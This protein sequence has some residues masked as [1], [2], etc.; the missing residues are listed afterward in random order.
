MRIPHYS[1]YF[2]VWAIRPN[3]LIAAVDQ[4]RAMDLE[5]HA[6]RYAPEKS[7]GDT[8]YSVDVNGVAT[9]DVRGELTKYGSSLSDAPAMS[10]IRKMMRAMRKDDEVKGAMFMVDSPGGTVYGL[11]DLATELES[12]SKVKPTLAFIQDVGASA[13]YY[14]AA[15]ANSVW[16][17][18][19]AVVGSIGT[20]A[21]VYDT[22][23]AAA[24]EGV[25]VHVLSTAPLKGAGVDGAPVTPVQLAEWQKEVDAFG[26]MFVNAVASGR[27]MTVDKARELATGEVWM[28]AKARDLGLVDKVGDEEDAYAALLAAMGKAGQKARATVQRGSRMNET[29]VAAE[30]EQPKA[31]TL[32]ELKATL[33]G[34][35]A[36]FLLACLDRNLTATEALREYNRK[37]IADRAAA[38]AAHK[39]ELDKARADKPAGGPGV[40]EAVREAAADELELRLTADFVGV[41]REIATE[42][43]L[44]IATVISQMAR[45]YPDAH[46]TWLDNQP[47]RK[48]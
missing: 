19:A 5:T 28:A 39:T 13:A 33:D 30:V 9:V 36:D 29:I 11:D 38:D 44:G 32:A 14:F 27:R 22:S 31:A 10:A 40:T 2:G 20:Y 18:N 42:K 37:L 17:N 48:W 45:E 1:Q 26:N 16:A 47:R 7:V 41:C 35:S 25:K 23:A 6:A 43:K 8:T 21:V 3:V 46:R 34:A 4:V 15:Q 12:L 24:M